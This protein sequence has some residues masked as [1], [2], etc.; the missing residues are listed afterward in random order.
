MSEPIRH[1]DIIQI[2]KTLEGINKI[3]KQLRVLQAEMKKTARDVIGFQQKQDPG[4]ASGKTGTKQASDQTA[5][6]VK[7]NEKLARSI[8]D[9]TKEQVKLKRQQKDMNTEMRR[10]VQV[11]GAAKGSLD[12]NR[13]ALQKLSERYAKAGPAAARKMESRVTSLTNKIKAQ[14]AAIGR[15]Q[16]NV[17]NYKSA[18]GS[19]L[20]AAKSFG[21]GMIGV[22]AAIAGV[23]RL[24]KAAKKASEE[25]ESTFVNVLTLLDK[26]QIKEFGGILER[27]ADQIIKQFGLEAQDVNKALFDAISA[28][29]GAGE[30]IEFLTA[31]AK[32]AVG[33]NAQLSDVVLGTTKI[34]NAY[35]LEAKDATA[36]T[37]ALF[38]AQKVG[39][40]TVGELSAS[41]GT[42]TGIANQAGIG[43][44]DLLSTFAVLTKRLKNTDE[45]ATAI[46]A[47]ITALINPGREAAE[48]FKSV[49]IESG[50]AALR[51]NGLFETLVQIVGASED[52]VD[53]LTEL[54]PNIRALKGVGALTA[55][56][57]LEYDQTMKLI[58][59]DTGAATLLQDAYNMQMETSVKV[60]AVR[61][62]KVKSQ[63]RQEKDLNWLQRIAL[64]RMVKR[65]E[66]TT[67]GEIPAIEDTTAAD[68]ALLEVQQK[69]DAIEA[70]RQARINARIALETK[71]KTL[72]TDANKN[73]AKFNSDLYSAEQEFLMLLALEEQAYED[74]IDAALR[75]DELDKKI[76]ENQTERHSKYLDWIR[77]RDDET[78]AD[79]KAGQE[80]VMYETANTLFA[81]TDLKQAKLDQEKAA[82][83]EAAKGN[84]AKIAAI[85]KKYAKEQQ[86]I[87]T[88]RALIDSSLAILKTLSSVVFPFNVIAAAM[89]AAQAGIQVAAI[90]SQTFEK[91]GHGELGGERHSQGGTYLPGIGEAE[92]GEYFGIINRQMT[93]KYSQDLPAIFDSLNAG[94]FHDVWSN[95]NIQLQE[96]IDPWTKRMYDLMAKTPTT[97]TDSNGDTVRE[98]PDGH[99]RVIRKAS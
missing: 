6:L 18:F 74:I 12:R 34:M 85:E 24:L 16:R 52:N 47:T 7:Q 21:A 11:M 14:E 28:G 90:R 2:D 25:F 86:K 62:E 59:D 23:S 84:K 9:V 13:V 8:K 20:A 83:I 15:H 44:D 31:S 54:I 69:L 40:T 81:L 39:Q 22:G 1:E 92:K 82:E 61:K 38:A 41:V 45:T 88:K 27:G 51:Q 70:K 68:A 87:D 53:I 96:N 29:V 35:A 80:A 71:Q 64:N 46:T 17:G 26:A 99:V 36:I 55:E 49:G 43:Y 19:A 58:N 57:L 73:I 48:A 94:R 67:S 98:Y 93:R 65:V 95:A 42:A 5:K 60:L 75:A 77:K 63:L 4:T 89:I 30:A 3:I 91:G 72:I 37:Q 66:L 50:I 33:G 10:Q 76:K 56:A 97:Y 32:L 79:R 78:E